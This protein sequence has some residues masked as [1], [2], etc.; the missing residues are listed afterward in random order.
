MVR[1]LILLLAALP[2]FAASHTA[3]D[4][5]VAAPDPNYKYE[6]ARTTAGRG[7]TQYVYD[8][9]SQKWRTEQ[10]VDHPLWHHWLTIIVPDK[11]EKTTAFLY[12]TGGAINSDPPEQPDALVTS[13]ATTTNTV[14][15]ELRG[16]P[17]EPLLFAGETKP[18]TEDAAIVYTWDKFLRGGD[19]TWPLRLP[20]DESRRPRHGYRLRPWR[21]NQRPHRGSLCSFWRI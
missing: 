3:L 18:R 9:I 1:T 20:A 10:D 21:G 17:N 13:I 2:A 6:L 16:I 4:R 14:A 11:V 12:L 7:Y 5:Y 19:E 8:M 15:A